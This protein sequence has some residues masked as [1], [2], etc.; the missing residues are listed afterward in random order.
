MP[1][2]NTAAR[3]LTLKIVYY[4]PGVGGKTTNLELI[5]KSMDKVA[6]GRLISLESSGERTLFFDMLPLDG[7]KKVR[8][9]SLRF[10]LYTVPGQ[11]YYNASRRE[12]LKNVD[13]IVFV[14]D[15]SPS[16]FEANDEAM[17][18]MYDNLKD[19]GINPRGVP[20][21]I[22]FNKRDTEGAMPIE[23]LQQ[24]LNPEDHPA[25]MA[26]AC[27]GIGVIETLR[28]A[29]KLAEKALTRD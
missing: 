25:F 2:V 22:Q 11:V 3:E 26:V 21:V 17:Q 12:V 19:L 15:S 24:T 1:Q 16:R 28:E 10:Q 13:G 29:I 8:G 20:V 6:K 27:Q 7:G 5:H 14:A 9:M 4:G 18:N 23:L